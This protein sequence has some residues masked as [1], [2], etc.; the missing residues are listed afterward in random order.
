M[1][2]GGGDVSRL[3]AAFVVVLVEATC[4]TSVAAKGRTR[5]RDEGEEIFTLSAEATFATVGTTRVG[6]V[7]GDGVG[8]FVVVDVSVGA[9]TGTK[10][11]VDGG[12]T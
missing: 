1:G 11:S 2:P 10:L 7:T 9:A 5:A 8:G 12:T 3:G 6:A 4:A